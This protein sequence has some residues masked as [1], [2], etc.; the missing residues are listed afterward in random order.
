MWLRIQIGC[1]LRALNK[2][3]HWCVNMLLAIMAFA[4]RLSMQLCFTQLI[5][6]VIT[7]IEEE[8]NFKVDVSMIQRTTAMMLP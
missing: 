8:P 3:A 6:Q 1:F 2:L 5:Q 4:V 7:L